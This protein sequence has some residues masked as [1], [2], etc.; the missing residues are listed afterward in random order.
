MIDTSFKVSKVDHAIRRCRRFCS[1]IS[2]SWNVKQ[3]VR[4]EGFVIVTNCDNIDWVEDRPYTSTWRRPYLRIVLPT[5]RRK[6]GFGLPRGSTVEVGSKF[7]GR[8]E[9]KGLRKNYFY[10]FINIYT[11][12]FFVPRGLNGVIN[13]S[14]W[15]FSILWWFTWICAPDI[16]GE[17]WLSSWWVILN[18][19]RG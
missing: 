15:N 11:C 17:D 7:S 13:Q 5:F 9:M 3:C 2:A 12:T 4:W 18:F 8:F 10:G 6:V 19:R 16:F 1:I 14:S